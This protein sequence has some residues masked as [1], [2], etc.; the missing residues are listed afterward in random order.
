MVRIMNWYFYKKKEELA[1]VKDAL[2]S[3]QKVHQ[4]RKQVFVSHS[5]KSSTTILNDLKRITE[6]SNQNRNSH[7]PQGNPR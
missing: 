7:V 2:K 1:K 6:Q 5:H 3:S 4:L